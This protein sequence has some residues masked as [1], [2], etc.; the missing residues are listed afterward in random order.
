M[1]I[2]VTST[3]PTLDDDVEGRLGR[4]A[5]FL[6]IDLDNLTV[7]SIPNPNLTQGGGA[8]IQSARLMA[9]KDVSV[10]LTGNCGPNA[11]KTF[12]Q[13]VLR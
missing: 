1:K 3:G 7:E 4:C 5:Y 13:L 9:N 2:A 10:I 8:G 12:A 11:H 6:V